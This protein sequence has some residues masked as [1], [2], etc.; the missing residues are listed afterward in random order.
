MLE[1]L[2]VAELLNI[3][4]HLPRTVIS[5]PP[6]I[7]VVSQMYPAAYHNIFLSDSFYYYPPIQPMK[8]VLILDFI[9]NFVCISHVYDRWYMTHP[10]CFQWNTEICFQRGFVVKYKL[11]ILL[12]MSD[13]LWILEGNIHIFGM[14]KCK[15][16][17]LNFL[18]TQPSD[19]TLIAFIVG[20]PTHSSSFLP[21]INSKRRTNQLLSTKSYLEIRWLPFN[22]NAVFVSSIVHVSKVSFFHFLP[23][24]LLE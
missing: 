7:L 24:P 16:V 6:V 20:G 1:K 18:H 21:F 2:I 14:F 12:F 10:I 17:E 3:T 9:L 13:L 5:S 22:L 4:F 11:R 8:F 15:D 23:S 19:E